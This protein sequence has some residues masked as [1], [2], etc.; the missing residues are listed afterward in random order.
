MPFEIIRAD[1]TTMKVDA[2]VNAAKSSLLGGGGV[3]GAIHK[4]AG[5][6]LLEECMG[7][8]GCKPGEAKL[9]AGHRLPSHYVI[10]TV[11][12][13]WHGGDQDEELILALCYKNSLNIA[14]EHQLKS[15]AFPLISSGA[16]GYPK[17]RALRT[18]IT[19][20]SDYVMHHEI[21]VYLVVFDKESFMLSEKLFSSVQT[22]IEDHYV[23]LQEIHSQFRSYD[24]QKMSCD[25]VEYRIEAPSLP[26]PKKT[27]R[28]D[29]LMDELQE[30]FSEH[31]IRLID[32]KGLTDVETYKRANIDRRL[33]SKIRS[34]KEYKPSKVT[35]IA[36]AIALELNLDETMDLLRKA[37]FTI[38]HS[39]KFD[40][41]IE[42]FILEGNYHIYEINEALFA[43]DQQLLGV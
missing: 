4:A 16:Y 22:F 30:T 1:I 40:L 13:V 31:L 36:F 37:G 33:F 41:I 19:V 32:I 39:S 26:S 6:M 2:I 25:M 34:D 14:T 21:L 11:G 42:Y 8:G 12:P 24:V 10:H 18:A 5:P 20:I 23:D 15:I 43:F 7:L 28:L 17:D 29:D 38:S 3:D 9:T 27:R 35:V